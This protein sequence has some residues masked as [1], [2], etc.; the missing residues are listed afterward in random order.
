[1]SVWVCLEQDPRLLDQYAHLLI[2]GAEAGDFGEWS[3]DNGVKVDCALSAFLKELNDED[4]EKA[5]HA[6]LEQLSDMLH[7]FELTGGQSYEHLWRNGGWEQA[8]SA[9]H[10]IQKGH[11]K[12]ERYEDSR[13][14]LVYEK[15]PQQECMSQ[16]QQPAL[17]Q[18]SPFA[19]HRGLR[20]AGLWSDTTRILR[21]MQQ[22]M[23]S[24][25]DDRNIKDKNPYLY[26]YQYEKIGHGW[27]QDVVK[28]HHVPDVDQKDLVGKLQERFHNSDS[29]DAL[30]TTGGSSSLVAICQSRNDCPTELLPAQVAQALVELD[31]GAA[32][33]SS[34]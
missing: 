18:L 9:W 12:L 11:V 5:Y 13:L 6:A 30:W 29:D 3:S 2:Q 23:A 33:S 16:Q 8:L 20:E 15:P 27:V 25:S 21:V 14:V 7:D 19:L 31:P 22:P 24:T 17:S 28:R 32:V 26:S 10:D 4:E 34:S 1:L